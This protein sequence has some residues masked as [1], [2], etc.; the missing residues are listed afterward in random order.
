MCQQVN[1]S[2]VAIEFL[3]NLSRENSRQLRYTIPKI[4]V[5]LVII[6]ESV[7]TQT[8]ETSKFE[9]TKERIN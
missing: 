7:V 5:K 9:F 1:V 6:V 3:D 8:D 4:H 2:T